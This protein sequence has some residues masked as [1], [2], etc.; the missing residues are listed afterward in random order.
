MLGHLQAKEALIYRGADAYRKNGIDCVRKIERRYTQER[1]QLSE[2]WKKDA[3][4]FVRG[5]RSVKVTL[6]KHGKSREEA[7]RKLQEAQARRHHLFEKATT[8]LRALHRRLIK[9]EI[10]EDENND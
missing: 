2:T 6:D 4:K 8:N 3:N 1:Q 9:H 10:E 5:I 7:R